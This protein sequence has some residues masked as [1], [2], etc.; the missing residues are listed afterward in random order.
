M[1]TLIPTIRAS[2]LRQQARIAITKGDLEEAERC[3]NA[4]TEIS[5]EYDDHYG[6]VSA[7]GLQA[8]IARRYGDDLQAHLWVREAIRWRRLHL[9]VHRHP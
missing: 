7:L 1:S 2:R 3:T 4:A 6:V 8:R 5:H 9:A